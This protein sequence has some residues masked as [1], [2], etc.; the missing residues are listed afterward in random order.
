MQSADEFLSRF[1]DV[2][3]DRVVEVLDEVLDER[4]QRRPRP[5]FRLALAVLALILAV[6]ASVLL[7]RS[8][9]AVCTVWPSAAVIYL[10][11]A[12][13]AGARRS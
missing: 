9:L 1:G 7:R 6:A 11:A 13:L 8:V 2:I 4:D 5:R 3:D 10:A 12:Q